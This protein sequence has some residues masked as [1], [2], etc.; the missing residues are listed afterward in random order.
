MTKSLVRAFRGPEGQ[1]DMPYLLTPGPLTT[2]RNVKLAMLA[3]WGSW[4]QELRDITADIRARIL[5][6]A[7]ADVNYECVLL[8]GAGSYGVEAALG[9]F[10]PKID[11]KTLIISNG[12][13]GERAVKALRRIGR[14]FVVFDKGDSAKPSAQ[15]IEEEL[16]ADPLIRA[17][18]LVHCETTSG[19]VNPLED[20]AMLVKSRG[21]LFM[22]DAMS[23]FGA[24]P[25]SMQG[26]G[27]DVMI[28][29]ANKCIEGVPGFCYVVA[30]RDVLQASEGKSHSMALD[31][32]DQWNY[33]QKTGQFRYTPP[34]HTLVAFHT[35]LKEHE[36][37]GGVLARLKRYNANRNVLIRGMREM[38]FETLLPENEL[39]PIIQT[40]LTPRD[41]GFEFQK[42][43]DALKVRG[44]VIYPGKITQRSSF[45]I[46]TIGGVDEHV[47]RAL[48][49]AIKEAL[50][51]MGVKSCKA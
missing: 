47:M 25:F 10:A 3:D 27:I 19:I 48:L 40:F 1:E 35:A 23:S 28:S 46:G 41:S 14:P 36:A 11:G 44:F 45:R 42:F 15:E 39:G 8:Q 17:V 37:Q 32:Y 33:M 20:I 34:T 30:K 26:L 21:L 51:E 24:I 5:R 18:L 31:L 43:Y 38:G 9:A 7:S 29:S 12:A 49:L 2:S 4:D 16:D 22:L 13:Y 50:Q 6:L